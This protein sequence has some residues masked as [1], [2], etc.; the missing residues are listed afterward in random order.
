MTLATSVWQGH[1]TSSWPRAVVGGFL[2]TLAMTALLYMGPLMGFPPMDIPALLGTMFVNDMG[3][4]FWLGLVMHFLIGSMFLALVYAYLVAPRL[5]GPGWLRGAL[6]SLF[7]WLAMMV[8]VLPMMNMI[9][10]LIST[11]SMMGPGFF[12]ANL[13]PMGAVGALIGHLIYGIVLGAYYSR[14]TL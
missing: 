3:A 13:G 10:P 6:Y 4:A 9:H 7:P 1:R 12:A 8:M 5:K 2:G 14:G 11:G